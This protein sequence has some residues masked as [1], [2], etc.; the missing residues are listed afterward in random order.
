MAH[1]S[2]QATDPCPKRFV[3]DSGL[4][5]AALDADIDDVMRDGNVLGR[6]IETFVLMQLRGRAV[7]VQPPAAAL[8]LSPV[9]RSAR[10]R[11]LVEM[12]YRKLIGIEVKATGAAKS[13]HARHLS[14]LRD[15]VGDDL[16]AGVVLHTGPYTYRLDDRIIAAPI[17]SIWS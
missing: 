4:A 16:I 7:P 1:Q 13:H 10:G 5:A 2:A 12:G 3:R 9:R 15:Q 17:A 14:W 11:P 8:P 6:L